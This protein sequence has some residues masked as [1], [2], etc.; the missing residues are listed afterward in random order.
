MVTKQLTPANLNWLSPN[1]FQIRIAR[2]P[3]VVYTTQRITLPGLTLG[4]GANFHTPFSTIKAPG[5]HLDFENF[6]VIFSVDEDLVNYREIFDWMLGLGFSNS[7]TQSTNL[8]NTTIGGLILSD[9]GN[10]AHMRSNISVTLL[11]NKSN[12]NIGVT[13]EDCFPVNLSSIDLSTIDSPEPIEATVEFAYNT[14]KLSGVNDTLT[15]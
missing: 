7:F 6:S 11:T 15:A 8:K 5:D 2:L 1:Q 9:M 3:S 10:F 13:F 12:A 14:Y 4:Q